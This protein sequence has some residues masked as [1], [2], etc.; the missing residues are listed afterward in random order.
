MALAAPRKVIKRVAK[1]KK[2]KI[3]KSDLGLSFNEIPTQKEIKLNKISKVAW[4]KLDTRLGNYGNSAYAKI[5]NPKNF[6]RI[7]TA[8]SA[9]SSFE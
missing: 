3:D 9:S 1:T 7:S 2:I 6:D 5:K 8:L 4:T